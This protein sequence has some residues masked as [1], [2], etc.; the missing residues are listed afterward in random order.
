MLLYAGSYTNKICFFMH[1][2]IYPRNE[3][4]LPRVL[5]LHF[6]Q[7]HYFHDHGHMDGLAR[8]GPS[9]SSKKV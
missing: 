6:N 7:S 5:L 3:R 2:Q 4:Q 1:F 9:S 8:K